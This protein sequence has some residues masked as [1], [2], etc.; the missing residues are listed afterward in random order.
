MGLEDLAEG[1]LWM[2]DNKEALKRDLE[3]AAQKAAD[4]ARAKI[5][6][7][8]QVKKQELKAAEKAAI[9]PSQLFKVGESAKLYTDF[10]DD[11]IPTKLASGEEISAKKKKDFAKDVA[12]QQKDFDKLA[13]Q[14]GGAGGIDAFLAKLRADV[15]ELERQV[16]GNLC[17]SLAP[18]PASAV[19]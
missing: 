19:L 17:G 2:F 4:A 15:Q 13:K 5:A 8:L 11:G 12:K 6:N 10:G 1:F 3:E 14:A 9:E 18:S 7:K 16:H